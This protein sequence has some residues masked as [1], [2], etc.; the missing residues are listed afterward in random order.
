LTTESRIFVLTTFTLA[1]MNILNAQWVQQNSGT[2]AMLSDVVMLDSTTAI[3]VGRDGSILKTIDSGKHWRNTAPQL[4][5][6]P[7]S[8]ACFMRWNAVSFC[9]SLHGIVVGDSKTLLTTDGGELWQFCSL[10]G[11]QAFLSAFFWTKNMI[12]V[13]DD[14]G[15]VFLSIDSG[16]TWD[17]NKISNQAI[18]SLFFYV[19]P[20]MSSRPVYALSPFSVFSTGGAGFNDWKEEHLPITNWGS[21]T[22]GSNFMWGDPAFIVGYDGQLIIAPVIFKKSFP[23][24]SWQRYSFTSTFSVTSSIGSLNDVT[25]PTSNVSFIC[26]DYGI[27]L[28]TIDS[29]KIWFPQLTG[30]TRNLY[31][32][33]FYNE[34]CG[35]A[36]GD[37]GTIL[38]TSSGGDIAIGVK[39]YEK[40]PV[41]FTLAQNYPNPFNP[42]TTI[43]FTLPSRS[44][45]SLKVFDLLG[46]EVATLV[47]ENKNAGACSVR[48]DASTLTS[49]VYFYR[50]LAGSFIETKKLLLLK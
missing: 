6:K 30:S 21:V 24:T 48:Y 44:F 37:S 25:V 14:S 9:D 31:A 38:Y 5:C 20:S 32:I 10:N 34:H 46:R 23:D 35:I 43:S 2:Y 33:D 36:V 27:V 40:V 13:G 12:Y 28:K 42:S 22:R 50:L 3:I 39:G 7:D 17:Y 16:K 49:G 8:V 26:G 41:E 19:T 47:N 4:D 15:R 1:Y 45:V 11:P 18:L 29:G